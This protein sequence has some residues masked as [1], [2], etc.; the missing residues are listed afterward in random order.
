MK[1]T[2]LGAGVKVELF[3]EVSVHCKNRVW[4]QWKKNTSDHLQA[5]GTVYGKDQL[6]TKL[7]N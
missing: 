7:S 5:S 2:A 4:N 6:K 3:R 1:A